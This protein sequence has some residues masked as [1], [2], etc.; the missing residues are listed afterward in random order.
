MLSLC[1][2]CSDVWDGRVQAAGEMGWSGGG[3]AMRSGARTGKRWTPQAAGFATARQTKT[4][5]ATGSS[6]KILTFMCMYVHVHAVSF[7]PLWMRASCANPHFLAAATPRGALFDVLAERNV[8]TCMARDTALGV[9]GYPS[10]EKTVLHCQLSFSSLYVLRDLGR[11]MACRSSSVMM[12]PAKRRKGR[13][14]GNDGGRVTI[15]VLPLAALSVLAMLATLG[16]S[17]FDDRCGAMMKQ[18]LCVQHL[19]GSSGL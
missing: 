14:L 19:P 7:S 10:V 4:K 13:V 16:F 17:F 11:G 2:C 15:L 6:P 18:D 1:V 9:Y 12:H 8:R 5:M 3:E